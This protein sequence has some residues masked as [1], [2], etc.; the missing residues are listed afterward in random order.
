VFIHPQP[1][2][3]TQP[4]FFTHT[5]VFFTP[6]LS[7]AQ[8][9][10]SL[11]Y[12]EGRDSLPINV[13]PQLTFKDDPVPAKNEQA[14][15][16]ASLVS[17][18][19]AFF[20]TLRDEKLKP[21][22]YH[23]K[24]SRSQTGMYEKVL[25]RTP[26]PLAWFVSFALFQAFPLDMS[27]YGH[28]FRSSRIPQRGMD[29]LRQYPDTRHVIV[30]RGPDFFPVTV[31]R[32]DGTAAPPEEILGSFR[33]ILATP[34]RAEAPPVG[35]LTAMDRDSWADARDALQAS[36][37]INA[38]TLE[39]IESALFAVCLE[40]DTCGPPANTPVEAL[41]EAQVLEQAR[42]ML[43]GDARNR[44]FDKVCVCV[45]ACVSVCV[46]VCVRVFL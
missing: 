40:H 9:P 17:A 5:A 6:R 44:W 29:F 25:S 2:T 32:E 45:C 22:I 27:Q 31:L 14:T 4:Y 46:R 11:M 36:D 10:W 1:N 38:A 39:E 18:S 20:R 33:A 24:P 28:L 26:A 13:S 21:D 8:E 37:P 35:V 43:H 12:L 23:R 42:V 30:Q 19:V 3:H 7:A 16:A 41:T 34:L 15:R